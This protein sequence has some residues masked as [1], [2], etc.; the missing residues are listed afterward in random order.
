MSLINEA[1]KRAKHVQQSTPPPI[2]PQQFQPVNKAPRRG[3]LGAGVVAV[4]AVLLLVGGGLIFMALRKNE[5]VKVNATSVE[6]SQP[7]TTAPAEVVEKTLV[8]TEV[9]PVA[10]VNV[11]EVADETTQQSVSATTAVPPGT[12]KLPK[13]AAAAT[14]SPKEIVSPKL[15]GIFYNPTR[16]SA[17]LNSKTVYVG[18]TVSGHRV[19]AITVTD[20]TVEIAGKKSVLTLED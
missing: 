2:P 4:V 3:G 1:L 15:R 5:V 6:N 11:Q 17:V 19:V 8:V 14:E 16:P 20:V 10:P 12:N 7:N 18:D 13:T 9:K